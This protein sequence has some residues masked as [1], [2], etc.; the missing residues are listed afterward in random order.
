[1]G[2]QTGP[3]REVYLQG[4]LA[5]DPPDQLIIEVQLPVQV[6]PS[7]VI[8]GVKDRQSMEPTIVN[9]DAF[10]VVGLPFT[11]LLSHE[12][13]EDGTN[14]E[15]GDKWDEFSARG[16]E[17]K[18]VSGAAVG[19]CFGMPN[20]KEPWYIAGVEVE[21]VDEI[22]DGMVSRS[23]PAQKYA[24]FACTLET[25]GQTYRYI[26]EE[27]QPK[28]GYERAPAADFE[29]YD[30]PFDPAHPEAMGLSVYWPIR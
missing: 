3:S 21:R 4:L 9:K 7:F 29:Y 30:G 24:V 6:I 15:I 28:S 25:L 14:N 8:P 2:L 19:L 11:G 26:N 22:P 23:V 17:V 5:A 18:H 16:A 20:D 27:W 1:M 10:M 13:F 12:P